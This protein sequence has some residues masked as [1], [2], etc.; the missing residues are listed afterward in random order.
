M[1][2]ES[3]PECGVPRLITGEQLWLNNGDIVQARDRRS[4][5]L[6]LE[7]EN[8]DPLFRGIEE[9][10]GVP[11]ERMVIAASRRAYRVYLR[12][13]VPGEVR[14]KIARREMDYEPIEAAFREL[15]ALN[16]T[17]RY[18]R[19]DMRFE[20]DDQDY[21]TVSISEPYSL[22]FCVAAHVGA[23]E[24]LT[25][26]DQGYSY[27]EVS[28]GLYHITTFPSPHP[29]E[30]K[31]RLHFEP[32]EHREGGTELEKCASCGGPRALSGFAWYPD[33]GVIV[34]RET[35]RRMCIQG[36]AL[37]QPVFDEL[38]SELGDIIPRAVVEAQRRFTRSGFFGL[39]D[40]VAGE[41]NFRE[42][43]ALRGLGNLT[44]LVVK[45]RGMH[46]RVENAALPLMLVGI[47]QGF[48]EMGMSVDSSV[49]WQYHED[50]V[51]E[52]EVRP[53]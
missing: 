25:G 10:I 7:T 17:G 49:D 24:A 16:G 23:I 33:R 12:A 45:R 18:E 44:E 11:L 52:V 3:C 15:G 21:D 31:G 39:A 51:L 6:F 38:E 43:L 41:E 8:L 46:V 50:G 32:Y 20:G 5:I 1:N 22:P 13:F 37:I 2:I 19:V 30:L 4:R 53:R 9:I 14:E 27:E 28:P 36:N 42:R 26:V 34:D 40:A 29:D 35:G 47:A 48:Y